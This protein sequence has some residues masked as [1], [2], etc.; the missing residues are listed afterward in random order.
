MAFQ[1]GQTEALGKLDVE[2]QA[3]L[4]AQVAADIGNRSTPVLARHSLYR[5]SGNDFPSGPEQVAALL[6]EA[7]VA[8]NHFVEPRQHPEVAPALPRSVGAMGRPRPK[9]GELYRAESGARSMSKAHEE[10][11]RQS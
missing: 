5:R 10:S 8:V 3:N 11:R 1:A 6:K 9:P 2:R 4:A 7:E